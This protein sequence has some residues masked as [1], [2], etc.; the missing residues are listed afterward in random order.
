MSVYLTRLMGSAE[1]RNTCVPA[2]DLE[3]VA[4][5]MF[6]LLSPHPCPPWESQTLIPAHA[7][8]QSTVICIDIYF[9]L[10]SNVAV[11]QGQMF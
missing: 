2:G 6:L 8:V 5:V 11:S 4:V 9:I 10:A 3:I 7:P 1:G